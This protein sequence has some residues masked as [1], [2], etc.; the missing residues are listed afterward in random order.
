M[1]HSRKMIPIDTG[2]WHCIN[3]Y[4]IKYIIE[5]YVLVLSYGQGGKYEEFIKTFVLKKLR[6]T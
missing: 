3:N 6:L 4:D 2:V 1:V 5:I